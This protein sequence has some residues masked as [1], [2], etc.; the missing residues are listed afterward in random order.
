MAAI[1]MEASEVKPMQEEESKQAD[2]TSSI[3]PEAKPAEPAPTD[4]IEYRPSTEA[5]TGT[6][7]RQLTDKELPPEATDVLCWLVRYPVERNHPRP[8]TGSIPLAK[9]GDVAV[10]LWYVALQHN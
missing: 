6:T 4:K 1:K 5:L 2:S 8:T 10:A 3:K 7:W 9:E